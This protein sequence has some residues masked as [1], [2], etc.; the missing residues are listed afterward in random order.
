MK[1]TSNDY[2]PFYHTYIEKIESDDVKTVLK[3]QLNDSLALFQ[4]LTDA[5]TYYRYAEG[6][7]S[8][9]Q[10]LGH[11]IDCERIFAYRALR[12]GRADQTELAGFDEDEYAK[13]NRAEA[14][15]WDELVMEYQLVR[16]SSI[17]LLSS[18]NEEEMA[19]EG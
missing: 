11:I 18:F 12:F 19:R 3:T 5:L 8:I 13:Y 10:L 2:A 1:P 14:R 17:A 16:H 7:W 9:K 6:K 4:S 15:D